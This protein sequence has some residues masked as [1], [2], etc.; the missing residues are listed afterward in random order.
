MLL[1]EYSKIVLTGG[2]G[3]LGS[4]IVVALTEGIRQLGPLG[5]GGK[6]V[7]CLVKPGEN[8]RELLSQGVEVHYGD[9]SD[10]GSCID[11]LKDTENSLIIHTAGVI[12][13]K[14]FTKDFYK[15]NVTGTM[16]LIHS[17]A[18]ARSSRV[19]ALSSNSPIGTNVKPD[20]KFT[21]NSPYR[22]YMGYG[23]SKHIM[24]TE[25]LKLCKLS[26][27]PD[28]TIIRPPWFY[29]PGQPPRQTEFFRM[30]KDGKFPLMGKGLNRRSMVFIAN[31]VLAILV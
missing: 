6:S 16:N 12:H 14:I 3:W 9:I 22:P 19:I 18:G 5:A 25:L 24:E 20:E 7:K 13:P 4:R 26:E 30:V 10:I 21:E 28:I 17:A 15:V 29:G 2:T 8:V 31:L 27:Y 11:I 23:K 1:S